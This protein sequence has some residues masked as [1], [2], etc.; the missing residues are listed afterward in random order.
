MY[1]IYGNIY[2]QYTPVMLAYIPYMDPM[3]YII[4]IY[5]KHPNFPHWFD[6]ARSYHGGSTSSLGAT[7]DFRRRFAES[8]THGA[9][10]TRRSCTESGDR[11]QKHQQM[12][13]FHGI[14]WDLLGFMGDFPGIFMGFGRDLKGIFL[15]FSWDLVEI[16]RGFYGLSSGFMGYHEQY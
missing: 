10:I 9:P 2:H 5:N 16:W 4:Y 14:L 3:G 12:G 8:N 6:H 11:E 1:A 15:G 7:G 13:D